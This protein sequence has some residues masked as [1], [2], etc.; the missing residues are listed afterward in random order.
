MK[1]VF[2]NRDEG[3]TTFN[4]CVS[5]LAL[6]INLNSSQLENRSGKSS[7]EISELVAIHFA[8]MHGLTI[9]VVANEWRELCHRDFPSIVKHKDGHFFLLI[10]ASEIGVLIYDQAEMKTSILSKAQFL[11]LWSGHAITFQ[12]KT[13]V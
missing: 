12:H 4:N 6:D 1:G 11:A 5:N 13:H 8:E 9:R 3:I 7:D 2:Q 10:R